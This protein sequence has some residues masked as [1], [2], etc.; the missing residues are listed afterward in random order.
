MDCL[1]EVVQEAECATAVA[2]DHV[3]FPHMRGKLRHSDWMQHPNRWTLDVSM[4]GY[5]ML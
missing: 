2:N 3:S 5:G 1:F 4:D